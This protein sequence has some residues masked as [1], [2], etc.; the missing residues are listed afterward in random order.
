MAEFTAN[1][2]ISEITGISPF[3]ANYGL[4][5]KID[6]E[7]DIPVDNPKDDQA[8]TLADCL[9]KIHDVFKSEMLFAQDQQQESA[10][11]H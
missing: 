4:N 9:S 11:R 7:P 1:N 2:H 5:P 6:F 10:D 8:W 3:F